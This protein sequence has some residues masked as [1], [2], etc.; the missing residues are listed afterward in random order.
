MEREIQ[1]PQRSSEKT[2]GGNRQRKSHEI[3]LETQIQRLQKVR[4]E[5]I[6]HSG[7]SLTKLE[8]EIFRLQKESQ[9]AQELQKGSFLQVVKEVDPVQEVD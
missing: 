4:Q 2:N 5:T 8:E 6:S 9:I 3:P 1:G 7:S